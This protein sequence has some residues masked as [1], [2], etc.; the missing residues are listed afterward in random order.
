MVAGV[1][2]ACLFS[3]SALAVLALFADSWPKS[4]VKI[5]SRINLPI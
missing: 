1:R 5:T 4:F 2:C 3:K